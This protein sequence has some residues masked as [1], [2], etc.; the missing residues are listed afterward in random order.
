MSNSSIISIIKIAN[1]KSIVVHHCLTP[2]Y[3]MNTMIDKKFRLED[4]QYL[5]AAFYTT[6]TENTLPAIMSCSNEL[7]S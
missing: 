6:E 5:S 7:L 2:S 1:A 4:C 3:F